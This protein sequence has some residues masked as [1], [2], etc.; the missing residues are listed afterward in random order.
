[1]RFPKLKHAA[2]VRAILGAVGPLLYYMSEPAREFILGNR[3]FLWPTGLINI[4][5][6]GNEHDFFGCSV[7]AI[8]IVLNIAL[9]AGAISFGL[10]FGSFAMWRR[11]NANTVIGSQSASSPGL[12]RAAIYLLFIVNRDVLE[13]FTF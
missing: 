4:V 8:S 3:L 12:V 6:Y 1:V 7:T 10:S 9:Y 13:L 2:F 5:S 11:P